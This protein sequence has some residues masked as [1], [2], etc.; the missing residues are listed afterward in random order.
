M[1]I[2]KHF[3]DKYKDDILREDYLL[4][5]ANVRGRDFSLFP[6]DFSFFFSEK[7]HVGGGQHG[8]RVKICFDREKISGFDGSLELFG[9][10]EF[11]TSSH[12]TH[13]ISERKL[14]DI[15]QFFR[16]YKVLFAAVWE[17]K[18]YDGYLQDYFKGRLT[19]NG[20][21]K[22]F[23]DI[24]ESDY[25]LIQHAANIKDLE[26]IVRENIIFNMND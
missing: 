17:D 20:L 5:M 7:S 19:F 12:P 10:Y 24:S 13:R 23:K 1:D 15:R 16:R 4:E 25:D 26:K 9:E 2:L 11:I 21:L 6:I 8:I 14:R 22:E 18:L 3:E